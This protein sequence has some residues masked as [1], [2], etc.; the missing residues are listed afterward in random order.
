MPEKILENTAR[1]VMSVMERL[2]EIRFLDQEQKEVEM[3][4]SVTLMH[5]RIFV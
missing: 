4:Q 2:V 5:G 1:H 3:E